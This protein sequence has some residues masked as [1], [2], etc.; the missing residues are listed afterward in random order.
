[1]PL[2]P[3]PLPSEGR[4]ES[5]ANAGG[6]SRRRGVPSALAVGSRLN[7]AGYF[8][9]RPV[10]VLAA[11]TSIAVMSVIPRRAPLGMRPGSEKH[12]VE[13]SWGPERIATGWWRGQDIQ[14][15]Y[16]VVE[17]EQGTRFWIFRRLDDGRWF[18]HGC[19]D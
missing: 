15:D 1:S 5:A 2:T 17:T 12:T 13:R 11:P 4:G 18:L 10:R 8:G 14:R 7:G 9:R 3:S 6:M 16:Y 19:F